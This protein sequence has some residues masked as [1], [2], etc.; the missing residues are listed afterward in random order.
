MRRTQSQ[1][2]TSPDIHGGLLVVGL[3]GQ[4]GQWFCSFSL[5]LCIFDSSWGKLAWLILELSWAWWRGL[6]L[7][8]PLVLK[9]ISFSTKLKIWV[10]ADRKGEETRSLFYS[11]Y[12]FTIHLQWHNGASFSAFILF[13]GIVCCRDNNWV[14]LK[15]VHWDFRTFTGALLAHLEP[16]ETWASWGAVSQTF[17]FCI[18]GHLF[19][20]CDF[21]PR[22]N[23]LKSICRS[24]RS[25]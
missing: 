1:V 25:V 14:F 11:P 18:S 6:L 13:P 8:G 9:L 10:L 15:T 16:I 12:G 23:I 4:E 2:T 24:S 3:P 20:I 19:C 21:I 22:L 5:L 7:P 17:Y